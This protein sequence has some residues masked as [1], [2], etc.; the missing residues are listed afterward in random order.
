VIE[1]RHVRATGNPDDADA[2]VARL[3]HVALELLVLLLPPRLVAVRV[4][5][6]HRRQAGAQMVRGRRVGPH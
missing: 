5:D 1:D 2:R 6:Q 3:P 4:E